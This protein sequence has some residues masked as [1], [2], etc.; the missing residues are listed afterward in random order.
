MELEVTLQDGPHNTPSKGD[1]TGLENRR[2]RDAHN[3]VALWEMTLTLMIRGPEGWWNQAAAYFPEIVWLRGRPGATDE[4]RQLTPED[5]EDELPQSFL[6][7]LNGL[8][9]AGNRAALRSQLP[10]SFIR[11]GLAHTTMETLATVLREREHYN[12]GPWKDF[13]RSLREIPETAA[14]L[15][16]VTR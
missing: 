4:Q 7:H 12:A 15:A 6:A 14:I 8:V 16:A 10:E 1:S 5:F 9:T 13:C 11:T 3:G 2:D